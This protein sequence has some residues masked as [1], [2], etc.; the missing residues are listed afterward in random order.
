MQEETSSLQKNNT[1]ELVELPKGR[2][3][4]QNKWVFKLKKYGDKLMKCKARLVVKGFAQRQGVDFDE[5]FSP[6]V[7][8]S[9][10]KVVLDLAASLNLELE[11]LDMK[12]TFL[13]GDSQEEIYM[14]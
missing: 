6:V 3:A 9:S 12:T 8:M 4:L 10:I 13:H 1:Y 2:K 14:K 7:K 5:I 11:Q